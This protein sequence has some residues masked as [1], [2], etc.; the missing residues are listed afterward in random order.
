MGGAFAAPIGGSANV[1]APTRSGRNS[2]SG[3]GRAPASG[4]SNR[5]AASSSGGGFGGHK[6]YGNSAAARNPHSVVHGSS[7]SRNGTP[8]GRANG[9][10]GPASR[11]PL[12]GLARPN[13]LGGAGVGGRPPRAAS[14]GQLGGRVGAGGLGGARPL[15]NLGP[16]HPLHGPTGHGSAERQLG[17]SSR[18]GSS[19]RSSERQ[20]SAESKA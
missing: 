15:S 10:V 4:V 9:G 18:Q 11:N 13:P 19:Q 12:G 6:A 8:N 17:S 5:T 7:G 3:S 20:G 16:G 2:T 1:A 14:A